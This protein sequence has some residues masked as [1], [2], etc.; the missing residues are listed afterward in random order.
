MFIL[1]SQSFIFISFA[2]ECDSDQYDEN[3]CGECDPICIICTPPYVKHANCDSCQ[4][5]WVWWF[6]PIVKSSDYR[7]RYIAFE[8]QIVI[9]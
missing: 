4:C 5:E 8:I 2:S 9:T 6:Y 7:Y 1:V 3:M